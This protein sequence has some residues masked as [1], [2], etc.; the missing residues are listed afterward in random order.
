MEAKRRIERLRFAKD[1]AV[2]PTVALTAFALVAIGGIAFDYSRLAALDTELQNAADQAALAAASQ[3]DGKAAVAGGAAGAMT[4]ATAAANT[5]VSNFT[6]MANEGGSATPAIAIASV[7]FFQDKG[8]KIPVVAGSANADANA[9]FVEVTVAGRR[10]FYA[11]TPVVGAMSNGNI[12]A[13]AFAGLGSA[14]CNVPPV[15]MCN[16]FEDSNHIGAAFDAVANAGAGVKLI[17]GAPNFPGNF[18]FLDNNYTVSNSNPTPDLARMLGYDK[19][20][21]DCVPVVDGDSVGVTPGN[22]NV[23]FNAFNTRFDINTNGANTCPSGGNCSAAVN[24]RKDLV[25][26]NSCNTS[27]QGWNEPTNPYR[28][29][30]STQGLTSNYP[31]IMGHPRDMCHA[32]SYAGTC[33][34]DEI[35]DKLWDRDAYFWVNYKWDNITW[36]S[37]T[38]LTNSATRYEVYKWEIAHP[39]LLPNQ[40]VSGKTAYSQPICLPAAPASIPDRRRFTMAVVNCLDQASKISGNAKVTVLKWVDVFLVEP[41]FNRGSGAS[42]RTTDD[43][44]YV[45]VI[46]ENSAAGGA[47]AGQVVR[48]DTPYLV[49]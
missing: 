20:V 40:T 38:G 30:S 19:P 43:Q 26:G 16:P 29:T 14:V 10:A 34:N 35:G 28:P 18:G 31:S 44:V 15:M 42:K 37:Q 7:N 45:E 4:R 1:G 32:V 24:V 8:K 48:H 17:A 5:L 22:R 27:A 33:A 41:A 47:T 3:L 36:R 6:R 46:G 25:K 39:N 13:K 9:H 49:E 2:A 21:G 11:L 12:D 23:V